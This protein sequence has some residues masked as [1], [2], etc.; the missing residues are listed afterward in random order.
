MSSYTL[1]VTALDGVSK[2]QTSASASFT[3]AS[4]TPPPPPATNPSWDP[5]G[6]YALKF[7]DDFTGSSLDT[8]KWQAGW[9]GTG[10]TGPVNSGET[11]AYQSAN[12]SVSN[13]SLAL[14]LYVGRSI[15]TSKGSFPN[16]GALVCT[17]GKFTFTFG[18]VEVR[19]YLPPSASG[20]QIANWPAIWCDGTG[21]WPA[22]GEMD[23]LEGLGGPAAYHFHS[24]AGGPGANVPGNYSGWHTF[25][26]DWE[27]G[28][29]TFYY[30][31][32]K[33]G[34]I[35]SGITSSPMY[36]IL[37]NTTNSGA[38]QAGTNPAVMLVDWVRVWSKG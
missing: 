4:V 21:N 20:S 36:V 37:N 8:A 7:S 35:T 16:T 15:S 19:A 6:S 18:Q 31:G 25:G 34:V 24:P 14:P 23:V 13:S 9:F 3:V 33:V 29:V 5:S 38:P 10:T 22:T 28:S 1:T 32:K 2:Q 17:L 26:A 12:L 30:D 11:A 27:S